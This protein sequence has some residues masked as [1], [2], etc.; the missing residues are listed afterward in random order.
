MHIFFYHIRS[1]LR[2]SDAFGD[3]ILSTIPIGF[4]T[5]TLYLYIGTCIGVRAVVRPLNGVDRDENQLFCILRSDCLSIFSFL[6]SFCHFFLF[7]SIFFTKRW[8]IYL[9]MPKIR[10][11][12]TLFRK[13]HLCTTFEGSYIISYHGVPQGLRC[14][15]NFSGSFAPASY[16]FHSK[17][18]PIVWPFIIRF[19]CFFPKVLSY[20]DRP[21]FR[22]ISRLAVSFTIMFVYE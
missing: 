19:F 17:N 5:G 3:F 14:Q 16:C 21:L 1:T 6:I 13:Q 11:P 7:R 20:W 9:V 4:A 8:L 18:A 10:R 2:A 12:K 22:F 15:S